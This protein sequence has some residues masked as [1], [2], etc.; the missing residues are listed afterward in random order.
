MKSTLLRSAVKTE[1]EINLLTTCY[2]QIS[3][4]F[5]SISASNFLLSKVV[6]FVPLSS[7]IKM[8]KQSQEKT[9]GETRLKGNEKSII[10]LDQ[11]IEQLWVLK[12]M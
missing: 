6:W 5:L 10:G 9:Y 3:H 8:L 7:G 1:I 11:D 2:D 12:K 4:F